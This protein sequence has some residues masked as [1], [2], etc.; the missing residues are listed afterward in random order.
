MT[1]TEVRD[2]RLLVLE[3]QDEHKPRNAGSLYQERTRDGFPSRTSR[4]H[5]ALPATGI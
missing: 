5:T 4:K 1:E 2:M 3:M